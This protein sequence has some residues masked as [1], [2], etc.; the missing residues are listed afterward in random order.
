MTN[1]NPTDDNSY[2]DIDPSTGKPTKKNSRY[3]MRIDNKLL[4]IAEERAAKEGR[5][6]ADILRSFLFWWAVEEELPSPPPP[7]VEANIKRAARSDKGKSRGPYKK[8]SKR[9]KN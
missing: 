8:R 5:S 7:D 3:T 9:K 1:D 2:L 4:E 6:L